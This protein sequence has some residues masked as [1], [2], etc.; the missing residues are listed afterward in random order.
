MEFTRRR[1][2]DGTRIAA[3][4]LRL[5]TSILLF[6]PSVV[7]AEEWRQLPPLPDKEGIAGAFAGLGGGLIVAGGANFPGKKPW[8]GGTKV[9]HDEVYVREHLGEWKLVGKL[10]RPLAYGVC[11]TLIEG[12]VICVGGSDAERHY[13]DAFRLDWRDG[14]LVTTKLPP[15]PVA[16][17]NACGVR[18]NRKLFVA[19]G[20][21]RYDSTEA[22]KSLWAIN[23]YTRSPKWERLEDLPGEGRIFAA[24]GALDDQ[25]FVFGGASLKKGATGAAERIYLRDAYAYSPGKGWKKLADLPVPSVAAPSPC[26][27]GRG[28]V[29]LLGGDDGSQVDVGPDAHRGF[30]K[31][32]MRYDP[33]EDRWDVVGELPAP[34]VTV[35]CVNMIL[36]SIIPSGE[37][38]PGIRS[39]EVWL[40]EPPRE[41]E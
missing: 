20:Q 10:P 29:Y 15:L 8:E 22:L 14:K 32:L 4:L 41:D 17:A 28:S 35:P 21:E 2:I 37:M 34:R 33:E 12:G 31:S 7:S 16:I 25:L 13:A 1:A 40:F 27:V 24:A 23:L 11:D 38:R 26:P 9:W 5:A 36:V 6:A 39:P 19:G 3:G 18:V 30:N